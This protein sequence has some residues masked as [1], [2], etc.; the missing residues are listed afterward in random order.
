MSKIDDGGS[1]FPMSFQQNGPSGQLAR[2]VNDGLSAL[3]YF[4]AKAMQAL[5]MVGQFDRAEARA[6]DIAAAMIGERNKRM[7]AE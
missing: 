2:Y 5:I 4:A 3:D 1:A 7:G 6:Y